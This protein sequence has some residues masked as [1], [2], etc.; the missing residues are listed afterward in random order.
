M[1]TTALTERL[2]AKALDAPPH[3]KVA[4][5]NRV[6]QECRAPF[7]H[8]WVEEESATRPEGGGWY[9]A[10]R[11]TKCGTTFKQIVGAFG[12]LLS[13]RNYKHPKDYRDT[14]HWSRSDWR[15]NFLMKL[16]RGK[17]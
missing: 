8:D 12:E 11:C 2:A 17:R 1:T 13:G 16:N 3:Y 10:M 15:L 4:G 7:N 9:L 14:D 6:H 5:S